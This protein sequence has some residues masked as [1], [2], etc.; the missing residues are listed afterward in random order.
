LSS[1]SPAA[2]ARK[3]IPDWLQPRTLLWAGAALMLLWL[4]VTGA[5]IAGLLLS[6]QAR[7]AEARSLLEG[8]LSQADP[9]AVE[10]L[11]LGIH[12][13]VTRLQA[14]TR[15]FIYLGSW[16]GR[17]PRIGP[18][19]AAAPHLVEMAA[20][21][22]EAAAYSVRAMK[23]ALALFQEENTDGMSPLPV[24]VAIMADGRADLA[25]AVESAGRATAARG[26][27]WDSERLPWRV[28]QLLD[29]SDQWLPFMESS[30]ILATVAPELMGSGNPKTYVIM[31]Q[32]EDE[33]RATGGFISSAGLLIVD[34]G[35]I[36]GLE[37]M[38][39]YLV[40]DYLN[41][42][43]D[44]PPDPLY[45]FMLLEGFGF[46]DANFWP[47]FAASAE[48][49]MELFTYG[50]EIPVDGAIAVDQRFV[51]LLV[52]ATGPLTLPAE[53]QVVTG[54]NVIAIMRDSWA[55]QEDQAAQSWSQERK[56]FIGELATVLRQRLEYEPGAL[57]LLAVAASLAEATAGKHLQLYVRDPA[58]ATAVAQSSW[59][60]RLLNHPG[61]DLLMVVDSNVGFN[62]VNAV[63]DRSLDYHVTLDANGRRQAELAVTYR[64][65]GRAVNEECRQMGF[66]YRPGITYEELVEDCYWNYVRVYT[67]Q[68]SRLVSGSAPPVAAASLLSGQAWPGEARLETEIESEAVAAVFANFFLLP[69][70]QTLTASF[71]YE[72]PPDLVQS[73]QR[74][75]YY[76]LNVP[77]QAGARSQPVEIQVTLPDG[78]SLVGAQPAP[79]AVD[80]RTI[81]FKTI[82]DRDRSFTVTFRP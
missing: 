13:D 77:K 28:R 10:L 31:V 70:G 63:V 30:L 51:Q 19:L 20:A 40:D 64:H 23:P 37:F 81:I 71:R 45:E 55:L 74:E 21:G 8:G 14:E 2:S 24:L 50:L 60:G 32:N 62:K 36:V 5:R 33:L 48:K 27:I 26:A 25:Q 76:R 41:K 66:S 54:D 16:F 57:D 42:P 79:T 58:L 38:D 4:L 44:W 67:P 12:S 82:L 1:S 47:D 61:Q 68:G 29:Q 46:R 3:P 59:D 43:Y 11:V 72:L 56:S 22:S 6:L 15:P 9:D 35:A 75:A 73:S 7:E 52:A 80:G 69:Q 18:T 53:E 78:A 17:L 49:A 65:N 34:Q 39:S